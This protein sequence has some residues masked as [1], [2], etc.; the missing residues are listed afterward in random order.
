MKGEKEK[1]TKFSSSKVVNLR[2]LLN[3]CTTNILARIMIGRR[4]FSDNSSNCDPRADE[5]KSMVVDLM[6][7]AGVW[8]H[9]LQVKI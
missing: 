2:Q 3:V 4:I 9:T 7:L 5:F 6:V 8:Y 1:S